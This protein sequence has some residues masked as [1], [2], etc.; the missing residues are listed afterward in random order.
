MGETNPTVVL[1]EPS[2]AGNIGTAARAIR[3]FGF[4]RL[5]LVDASVPERNSEA[6]GFA[7]QAREDVLPAA[8][9]IELADL[10]ESFLTVGFTSTPNEDETSH[11]RFPYL[12]PAELTDELTSVDSDVALVFGPEQSGLTNETLERLD[13]IC[14]IPAADE[15]PALNLGQAVTITLYELSSLTSAPTQLADRQI[16]RA[17]EKQIERLYTHIEAYLEAINHPTEKRDKASRLMRRLIG[18]AHPTEREVTTLTGLFRRG[19]EYARPPS[20]T[21]DEDTD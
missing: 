13:L 19:A 11:V 20:T 17:D 16:T 3:N 4:S 14:A 15:Y 1:V 18:R 2:E 6:Y 12:T 21:T 5:L 8:S 10:I 7:G 9:T